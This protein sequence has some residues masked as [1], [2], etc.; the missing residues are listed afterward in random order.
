[1]RDL[2]GP[3]TAFLKAFVFLIAFLVIAGWGLSFLHELHWQWLSGIVGCVAAVYLARRWAGSGRELL[4][5][6]I[7]PLKFWPFLLLMAVAIFAVSIY[8]ITMLDSLTYRLPRI[9]IWLQDGSVRHIASAEDRLNYMP[10]TWGL[11]TI[12]LVQLAGDQ[13]VWFWGVLSWIVLYLVTFDWALE[14]GADPKKSRMLAFLAATTTFAVLQAS[15][16]ANDIFVTAF[17]LLSLRFVVAFERTRHWCDINW[18]VL[19]FCLAAGTKPHVSV[20]GLPLMIWF[21]ASPA[22]PWKAFRWAWSPALLGVWLLCSP[23]PSFALNYE[24]YGTWAGPGQDQ[25]I[26]GA[27][28]QYD[29]P[30]GTAMLFWQAIQPPVNPIAVFW[31]DNLD[32][33]GRDS[34]LN[35]YV[36]RFTLKVAPFSVVDGASLGSIAAIVFVVGIVYALRTK[37]ELWRSWQA[38]AMGTGF[39]CILLA[40]ARFV[41]GGCGR[42]YCAFL[43][44]ALPL[45]VAG[46]CVMRETTLKIFF[47]LSFASSIVALVFNPSHPLWPV[48]SVQRQLAASPRFQQIAKKLNAYI[49]FSE[50]ASAGDDIIQAIPADEKEFAALVHG[51]RPMLALFRPYSL[52]R[53]VDFL[54]AEAE[55]GE[56]KR[57]NVRYVVV[58]GAANEDYPKL[59]DYIE[60][61]GDYELVVS[62][63]YISK[64]AVGAE[65]W[66]LYRLRDRNIAGVKP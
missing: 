17:L 20:F 65:P 8:P 1:M 35:H 26:V 9:F 42:L 60:K 24:T 12:P 14:R 51:D 27:G 40:M 33:V 25:S 5:G 53:K 18:A 46:W 45:A 7:E 50:R 62:R 2:S 16:S 58:S 63:D 10:Q 32:A 22:K 28:P 6:L 39:V 38:A 3:R 56:L 47:S 57:L 19:A 49:L 64:V 21:F 43:Y 37:P 34:G 23:A 44:L 48:H 13:L 36:P 29:I 4:D 66:K 59:C 55:P 54:P 15:S 41:P 61:S 30:V 11:A 52:H 31:D